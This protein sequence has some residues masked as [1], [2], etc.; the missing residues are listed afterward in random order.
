MALQPG[1]VKPTETATPVSLGHG[2]SCLQLR[3]DND[4]VVG[5]LNAHYSTI[6]NALITECALHLQALIVPFRSPDSGIDES[7]SSVKS[8]SSARVESFALLVNL[9]G[10]MDLYDLVGSYLSQCSENL[11]LPSLCDRNVPYRNPQ[12]LSGMDDNPPM[13]F[14][15]GGG[16]P[17]REI[18]LIEMDNDSSAM[19]ETQARLAECE[20]PEAIRTP[21]HR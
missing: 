19:L 20:M 13:T 2:P 21:L 1:F 17:S 6:L 11:Q 10:P 8:A 5:G 14:Y 18:E 9:Y 3:L 15:I 7:H 4:T 12:S 16:A